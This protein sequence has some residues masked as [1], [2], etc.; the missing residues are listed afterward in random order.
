MGGDRDSSKLYEVLPEPV[1]AWLLLRRAGLPATY[2]ANAIDQIQGKFSMEKIATKLR[3]AWSDT[4]VTEL[5]RAA[6]ASTLRSN[7]Y[8]EDEYYE[9]DFSHEGEDYFEGEEFYEEDP[10]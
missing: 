2:R 10:Y 5:N 3:G 1:R 7:Y 4:D 9:E 6:T 8:Q